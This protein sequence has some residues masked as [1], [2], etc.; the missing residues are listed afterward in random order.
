MTEQLPESEMKLLVADAVRYR[1]LRDVVPSIIYGLYETNEN[2]N[3]DEFVGFENIFYSKG[4][5]TSQAVDGKDLDD[6]IDAELGLMFDR[7][8]AEQ[9]KETP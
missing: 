7:E 2:Y 3:W 8:I 5:G 6:A 4:D 1:F 9:I